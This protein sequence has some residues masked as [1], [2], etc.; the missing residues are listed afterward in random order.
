MLFVDPLPR[1]IQEKHS[2]KKKLKNTS[3]TGK[4]KQYCIC[5]WCKQQLFL[6]R[7]VICESLQA[8]GI[9]C[10]GLTDPLGAADLDI[11]VTDST[12]IGKS[13]DDISLAFPFS[14]NLRY[15]SSYSSLILMTHFSETYFNGGTTLDKGKS[16][17]F[18]DLL[19]SYKAVPQVK[20]APLVKRVPLKYASNRRWK[21]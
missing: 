6:L 13:I 20:P 9:E 10:K 2:T 4:P 19:K 18:S 16:F 21:I 17:S 5:S 7:A 1:S 3:S 14:T 11:D 8:K 12:P 15:D